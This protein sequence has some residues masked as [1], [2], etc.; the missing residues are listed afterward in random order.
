[1]MT[2]EDYE[3]AL[4]THLWAP[5]HAMNAVIP[6]MQ[7]RRA[8][9]IVNIA[10]I[11][12][13]VA[14]PHLVPYSASKFA[15]Y[16]LSA[17]M[18]AELAK[19][20]VYVTTASP[21]L[22]RT[23]SPRNAMFRGNHRAEYAWFDIADNLPLLSMSAERAAC[24]I[25]DACEH[26][27]PEVVPSLPAKLAVLAHGLAPGLVQELLGVVGGLLPDPRPG[28]RARKTGAESESAF[29]PS[30]LTALGDAAARRNNEIKPAK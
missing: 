28:S 8:G 29:A 7:K 23:G 14:M 1:M 13:R 22:M 21:G 26:G 9:R 5:L 11:G 2:L 15:L 24:Q 30:I 3:E 10:S 12:A 4:R 16:G 18:R 25:L 27:D 20:G 17:A 6:E 19:D